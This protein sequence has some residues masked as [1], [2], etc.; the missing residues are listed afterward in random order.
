MICSFGLINRGKGLE[1]MIQAM[2]AIVK[3]CPRA[4]YLIVG[5][6]H[7]LV[8]RQEGEVYREGLAE[9]AQSLGVSANVGFVNRYLD[10][11]ELLEYL[12]ACDAYVTPYPGKDQIAS[13]T[14][15]YALAVVAAVVSTPY[16]YAEEVLAGGR[17][18]I[19]PFGDSAARRCVRAAVSHRRDLPIGNVPARLRVRPAYVMEQCGTRVPIAV[20]QDPRQQPAQRREPLYRKGLAQFD[21]KYPFEPIMHGG[22]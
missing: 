17:G 3:T 13:G 20:Q 22:S 10:L 16:L 1:H 2:P 7:P 11:P 5:A 15:A 18:L 21:H 6:T 9:L 14:L 8:K 4:L 19:A 12:Q